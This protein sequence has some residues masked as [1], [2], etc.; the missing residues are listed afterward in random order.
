MVANMYYLW[1]F[2]DVEYIIDDE[3]DDDDSSDSDSFEEVSEQD[4]QETARSIG[5]LFGLLGHVLCELAGS[6]LTL[7]YVRQQFNIVFSGLRRLR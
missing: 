7:P 2:S 5:R 6:H 3:D 1:L 4:A